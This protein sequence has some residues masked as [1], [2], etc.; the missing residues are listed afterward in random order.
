[1][2]CVILDQPLFVCM[3]TGNDLPRLRKTTVLKKYSIGL[4]MVKVSEGKVDNMPATPDLQ[5][6]HFPSSYKAKAV[7]HEKD[8]KRGSGHTT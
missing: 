4:S 5:S 3:T 2:S 6:K 1:V 8:I 7:G